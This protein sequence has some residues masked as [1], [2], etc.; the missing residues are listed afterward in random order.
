MSAL[1]LPVSVGGRIV[2]NRILLKLSA[3]VRRKGIAKVPCDFLTAFFWPQ[4]QYI[5]NEHIAASRVS[6]L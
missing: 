3:D 6:T 5:H 4:M 2:P 1:L